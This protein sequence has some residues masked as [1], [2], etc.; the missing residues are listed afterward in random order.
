M[1]HKR[2]AEK[3]KA[4]F[5]WSVI[6]AEG[7]RLPTKENVKD[8]E[9]NNKYRSLLP[10]KITSAETE[11]RSSESSQGET[12][13]MTAEPPWAESRRNMEKMFENSQ[14]KFQPEILLKKS[15]KEEEGATFKEPPIKRPTAAFHANADQNSG[16]GDVATIGLPTELVQSSE[17]LA[18]SVISM[19]VS[20]LST[21]KTGEVALKNEM[22]A[23]ER[24]RSAER[25][26]EFKS[27][28]G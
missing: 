27:F 6:S 14:R 3:I 11:E 25:S 18:E 17:L 24:N 19:S 8:G 16:S 15:E 23:T 10:F 5:A 22:A 4:G 21:E 2:L 7:E 28:A 20:V 12:I 9:S 13:P 1:F 26:I